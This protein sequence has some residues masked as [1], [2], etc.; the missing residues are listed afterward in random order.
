MTHLSPSGRR[1][2]ALAGSFVLVGGLA[3][4]AAPAAQADEDGT[5]TVVHG[6]PGLD[7]DVYVNGENTLPGFTPGTVT[8]PLTL[9]AGSY[10]IE[11]YAAGEG[12]DG[13]GGDAAITDEV[14]LPAG[15]NVSLVAHLTEE[16]TPSP[17]LAVFVNDV[18][19]IAAGEA[20]VTVRH[21]A[22]APAVTVTADG[23]TLI[24]TLSNPDEA[25]TDVPAATY[26]VAVAPAAGGDAVFETDLALPE[27]DSTIVYAYG[28]LEEDT[29]AVTTQTIADLGTAPTGV[30]AGEGTGTS[31][32][33]A[34]LLVAAVAGALAA[35]WSGARLLGARR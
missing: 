14:E 4:V 5:V 11:I 26:A 32:A 30:P 24:E 13:S 28:S 16:G 17:D 34:W 18:D 6:I 20:R 10:T 1:L 15:A 25:G 7:V 8:D 3:L 33:P 12:P 21:V 23:N 31:G 2:T 27:G 29:F 9:P 35:G 19:A 22:A